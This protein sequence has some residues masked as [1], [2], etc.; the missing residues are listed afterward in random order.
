MQQLDISIFFSFESSFLGG[1]E[2]FQFALSKHYHKYSR[3]IWERALAGLIFL[4]WH[5]PA[6][7]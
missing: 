7:V 6:K 5:L 3:Y 2:K 4:V 1:Y